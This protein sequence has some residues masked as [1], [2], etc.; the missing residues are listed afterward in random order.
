MYRYDYRPK[1]ANSRL[2]QKSQN[3]GKIKEIFAEK[4]QRISRI[5]KKIPKKTWKI[6]AYN[7]LAL[8]VIF[9]VWILFRQQTPGPENHNP[10]K[11]EYERKLPALKK[12]AESKPDDYQANT[13]YAYALYVTGNDS[14][15]IEAYKKVSNF[16]AVDAR[17]LNNL[18]NLYRKEASFVPAIAAYQRSI[19]LDPA[20]LNAYVNL[21]HM[22]I[23][24]LKQQEEGFAVFNQALQTHPDNLDILIMV[25][26]TYQQLGQDSVA[27]GYY[28]RVLQLDPNNQTA[29]QSLAVL[30]K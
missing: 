30:K 2:T 29:Q 13:D 6:F 1:R 8:L 14:D 20:Q 3:F 9:S 5:A 22:Y 25:A 26:K 17:S 21:A 16:D 23:Y 12:T 18:G 11:V 27:L 28:E 15:A 10:A 4:F 7:F 24:D 19:E